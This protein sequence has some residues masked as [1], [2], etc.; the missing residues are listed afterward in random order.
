[1]APGSPELGREGEST[2]TNS[3]AG[4]RPRIR[5]QRG[6]NGGEKVSGGMAGHRAGATSRRGRTTAKPNWLKADANKVKQARGRESHL[7]AELREAWR[8]LRR[9]GW[10]GTRARVSGGCWRHGQSTREGGAA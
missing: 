10:P 3:M 6:E 1:V 7:R 9:A 8:G 5:G 4:K 2:T